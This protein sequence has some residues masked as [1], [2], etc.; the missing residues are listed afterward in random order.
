VK[1]LARASA[2]SVKATEGN[3]FVVEDFLLETPKTK[4]FISF[5]NGMNLAASKPLVITGELD[6]NLYL[7]SRNLQ[8]SKVVAL[9]SLNTYDIINARSLV[10][11]EGTLKKIAEAGN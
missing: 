11:M 6:K 2:L 4:E 1:A 10:L 8:K 5:L 9:D 7:S 3:I